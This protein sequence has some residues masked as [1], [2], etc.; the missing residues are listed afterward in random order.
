M[1][2]A[3]RSRAARC[4]AFLASPP[5]QPRTGGIMSR[6]TTA[7]AGGIA[8]VAAL[9]AGCGSNNE[10]N[11]DR[12]TNS[13][14]QLRQQEAASE[15]QDFIRDREKQLDELDNQIARMDARL[16]HEAQYVDARQRAEW[17]QR[18]F[19]LREEQHR[20][21]AELERAQT[22]TPEEWHEMRG[23][24][25]NA[26]DSID[27]RVKK[28][29]GEMSGLFSSDDSKASAQEAEVNLCDL[30]VAGANAELI[31]QGQRLIVRLTSDDD[32]TVQDLQEGAEQLQEKH[33]SG[34]AEAARPSEQS[35]N[36]VEN[37]SVE[38]EQDG[39]RMIFTPSEG[40]RAALRAQLTREVQQIENQ[41]C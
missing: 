7:W 25:G 36:L 30:K 9:A 27:A 10:T 38:D 24:L 14:T 40:H 18:L 19:E 23:T 15:R 3:T 31:D 37:V 5:D 32:T 12:Q 20:T 28:L 11:S 26:V 8:L 22:A 1:M 29:G 4:E 6:F 17:S 39:V 13:Y 21:R 2:S 16:D 41:S 33:R 35:S 34:E